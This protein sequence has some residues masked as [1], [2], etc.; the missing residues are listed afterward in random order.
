MRAPFS[1][2]LAVAVFFSKNCRLYFNRQQS[3]SLWEPPSADP[4]AG[5]CGAGEEKPPATRLGKRSF[6]IS[7]PVSIPAS[8]SLLSAFYSSVTSIGLSTLSNLLPS[9]LSF[10]PLATLMPVC[11]FRKPQFLN[12]ALPPPI[13]TAVPLCLEPV[14]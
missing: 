4:H 3:V 7:C 14:L 8:Y 12:V 6:I 9:T 10:E 2:Q 11:K 1:I 5:W 13:R